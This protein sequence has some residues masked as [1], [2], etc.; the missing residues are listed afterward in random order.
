MIW[1]TWIAAVLVCA[2]ALPVVDGGATGPDASSGRTQP[3]NLIAALQRRRDSAHHVATIGI[4]DPASS[5]AS[6]DVV[7]AAPMSS[8][9]SP[10]GQAMGSS[11]EMVKA[12]LAESDLSQAL[13]A[14]SRPGRRRRNGETP[15]RRSCGLGDACR[16]VEIG[17]R[18]YN[19]AV[20]ATRGMRGWRSVRWFRLAGTA[21]MPE[22]VRRASLGTRRFRRVL[23][24]TLESGAHVPR[25][26]K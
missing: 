3:A 25:S 18:F 14:V 5:P 15:R 9:V 2:A 19:D 8:Q 22:T 26:T 13:G 16:R 21:T 24:V 10:E 11:G 17:R 7:R 1:C 4:L 12:W 20:L 23:R 6:A